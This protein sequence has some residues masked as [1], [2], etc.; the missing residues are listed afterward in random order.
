MNL[1]CSFIAARLFELATIYTDA[2]FQQRPLQRR[3]LGQTSGPAEEPYVVHRGPD[4]LARD[5]VPSKPVLVKPCPEIVSSAEFAL[6]G[7]D[8]W[9]GEHEQH[10]GRRP[11]CLLPPA[12]AISSLAEPSIRQAHCQG[13]LYDT[14]CPTKD[15]RARRVDCTSRYAGGPQWASST[16]GRRQTNALQSWSITGIFGILFASSMRRKT[17]VPQSA[18]R[19]LAPACL[20]GRE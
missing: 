2:L 17:T 11:A 3:R 7:P 13:K 4:Q 1:A 14:K 18:T 15:R 8:Y 9:H 16:P 12:Q 10:V 19:P 5:F 6:I 20:P